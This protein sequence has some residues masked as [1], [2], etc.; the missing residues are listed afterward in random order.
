MYHLCEGSEMTTLT[1]P[2]GQAF[3]HHTNQCQ[4]ASLVHCAETEHNHHHKR[5]VDEVYSVS[6]K[7]MK[8][9]SK[10]VLKEIKFVLRKSFQE[11]MPTIFDCIQ[12]EFASVIKSFKTDFEPLIKNY[13]LPRMEKYFVFV[14]YMS[15]KF[16]TKIIRTYELSNSTH[17]N[18]VS[19]SDEINELFD[20]VQPFLK[21]AEFYSSRIV[22][23]SRT[24][25]DVEMPTM[26]ILES[27]VLLLSNIEHTIHKRSIEEVHS[28]SIDEL[29]NSKKE[30]LKNITYVLSK[31]FQ[32]STPAL[33]DRI[34]RD[35]AP[36]IRS[37]IN[38][39]VHVFKTNIIPRIEKF[40]VYAKRMGGKILK[41]VQRSYD[42]SNST[43][44]NLVSLS[45]EMNEI[46]K[47]I[48][49][50]LKLG[51]YFAS[52]LVKT[53]RIKREVLK[54]SPALF[55]ALMKSVEKAH[56]LHKRSIEEVHSVSIEQLKNSTKEI[57]KSVKSIV[58]T[59]I[60]ETAPKL[61][62]RFQ[63]DY[64]PIIQSLKDEYESTFVKQVLPRIKKCYVYS[65]RIGSKILKK[66]HRS[67]ELSNSTHINLVSLSDELEEISNDMQPF[68]K[69][70][71]YFAS[72]LVKTGRVKRETDTPITNVPELL[73]G[74][75]EPVL[76]GMFASMTT[77]FSGNENTLTGRVIMPVVIEMMNDEETMHDVKKIF[78]SSKAAFSPLIFEM[79][80]R[81]S[82]YNPDG[83]IIRVP[84]DKVAK[85]KHFFYQE[86][87]PLIKKLLTKH[88]PLLLLKCSEN[89]KL[90]FAAI[91][92]VTLLSTKGN[93]LVLRDDIVRFIRKHATV[94][95]TSSSSHI[96]S[97]TLSEIKQDLRPIEV[98]ILQVA[99]DYVDSLEDS[100]LKIFFGRNS[101]MTQAL[102]GGGE[103]Y[104][105]PSAS[106]Q[107]YGGETYAVPSGTRQSS[108]RPS[109]RETATFAAPSGKRQRPVRPT[110]RR[111]TAAPSGT[112][113]SSFRS[114]SSTFAVASRTYQNSARQ[115]PR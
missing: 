112:H 63:T 82:F 57:L 9:S 42:I 84:Q 54:S 90:I 74:Y 7:Q 101:F 96:N 12:T 22:K 3:D 86:T 110:Y 36:K 97:Y 68:L 99:L 105:A 58:K 60:Q 10:E 48:Q 19:F 85:A 32:E 39:F 21:L 38:N 28:L 92:R 66:V 1:C 67:Y 75:L 70:G 94:M 18:L 56:T 16:L 83:T 65:K 46:S 34:Q 13:I 27:F 43:H 111:Q 80:N 53:G 5:S 15:G 103:T 45:D 87:K 6:I 98:G 55:F 79:L 100:W 104:A 76:K 102:Y 95:Q 88:L 72:R 81:Q 4:D 78:W 29:K 20:S 14:Q 69:L 109:R 71:K 93:S 114:Q 37:V 108:A 91:D 26:N 107:S 35:Y 89:T 23:S 41:K 11:T 33:Y 44:I 64:V 61:Y 115:S 62:N 31:A 17:I 49:P 24:K 59:A 73:L 2:S 52:R 77:M 8:N 40:N 25:R 50:L 47:D 113:Q 106:R 30:V 51:Q